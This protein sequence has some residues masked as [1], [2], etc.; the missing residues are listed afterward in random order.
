MILFPYE[1]GLS[2]GGLGRGCNIVNKKG[3]MICR[4]HTVNFQLLTVKMESSL[5]FGQVKDYFDQKFADLELPSSSKTTDP[6]EFRFKGNKDQA[7]FTEKVLNKLYDCK[8]LVKS[9]SVR[10]SKDIL[11]DVI[12]DL[13]KRLKCIKIA[14]RSAGGWND[15]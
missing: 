10:R 1:P 11:N 15:L 7:L 14:D 9:G 3:K 5:T 8:D 2:A 12:N 13:E 4:I 6:Y